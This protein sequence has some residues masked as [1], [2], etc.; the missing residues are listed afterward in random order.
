MRDHRTSAQILKHQRWDA[1]LGTA[2]IRNVRIDKLRLLDRFFEYLERMQVSNIQDFT[3]DLF[4][5]FD[6][7]NKNPQRLR[8]L[9][10][11]LREVSP[12]HPSLLAATDALRSKE[13]AYEK[14]RRPAI[15]RTRR[16]KK[17][18]AL[19]ALPRTWQQALS[20]MAAGFDRN[21]ELPP[22][23]AMHS[24]ITMKMRQLGFEAVTADLSIE[25][26]EETVRAYARALIKRDVKPA[27]LRA[28]FSAV[29]K[30]ARYIGANEAVIEL[31]LELC[32]TYERKAKNSP[33]TKY[34]KLQNTGYSPIAIVQRA[35]EILDRAE[36]KQSFKD[37][38]A[39]RNKAAAL[40]LFSVLPIRLADTRL[41]F[42]K[43]LLWE[44]DRYVIRT[45][46][47]KNGNL[48][49]ADVDARLAKFIDAL[50]LRGTD[51]IWLDTMR[52]SCINQYRP[53][54]ITVR[55]KN[56]GYNYVSD[57]WRSEFGTGEHIARTILHTFLG[58]E[59]GVAGTDMAMAACGQN[60]F[61]TAAAYQDETLHKAQR[62]KAQNELEQ[63]AGATDLFEFK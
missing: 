52:T 45:R 48:W 40:A 8:Y 4:L 55:G 31:L 46:L 50:I 47:S 37:Q 22:T 14:A 24:T 53:L 7:K 43:T 17:S 3:V 51:A 33:K 54:F 61:K 20:D 39:A 21:A 19:T 28:S 32:R 60:S 49:T 56:V 1:L 12:G 13:S 25:L 59:L 38:N 42:G 29:L 10:Q 18:V 34:A 30:F 44:E 11:A 16:L 5:Q 63:I 36:N 23:A 26:S 9:T 6:A 62:V 35:Q 57:A 41:I 15:G 58:S 27:T 2:A